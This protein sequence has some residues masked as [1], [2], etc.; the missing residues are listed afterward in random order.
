VTSPGERYGKSIYIFR[1]GISP[2]EGRNPMTDDKKNSRE[3][4][5]SRVSG[6]E[7][8]EVRD[9]AEKHGISA[10]EAR[11]LIKRHGNDREALMAAVRAKGVNR[12]A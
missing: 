1:L 9:F 5:R 7:D 6:S 3:P 10:A 12:S 8:Y 11:D 4:D 2:G